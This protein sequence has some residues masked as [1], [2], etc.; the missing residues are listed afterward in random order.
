MRWLELPAE[1][2]DDLARRRTENRARHK[3]DA[4]RRRQ[5]RAKAGLRRTYVALSKV[6][7]RSRDALRWLV[8]ADFAARAVR[9]LRPERRSMRRALCELVDRECDRLRAELVEAME[10]Y[11]SHA[12]QLRAI[13][14][15]RP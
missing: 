8:R 1:V 2:R 9:G 5:E 10:E 12:D 6:P 13:L 11:P 4:A 14:G 3:A 15:Q 7:R